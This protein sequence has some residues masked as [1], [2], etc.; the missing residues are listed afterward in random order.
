[1]LNKYSKLSDSKY[2]LDTAASIISDIGEYS[3]L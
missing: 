1:M 2:Y 3:P